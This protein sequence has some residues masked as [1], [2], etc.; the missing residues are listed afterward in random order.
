MS[1]S[2]YPTL[3]RIIER[4]EE[5]LREYP[6]CTRCL[7][8][9][10][11]KY[12]VGLSNHDRGVMI[13]TALA[14]KIYSETNTSMK[15]HHYAIATN[16]GDQVASTYTKLYREP[17]TPKPCY[18]C[19]HRL[20]R[21]LIVE[22]ARTSCELLRRHEATRF[23]VGVVI[24]RGILE[25]ELELVTKYG[26]E[27]SE[28]IKRELKREIGKAIMELCSLTPDFNIPDAVVMVSIDQSFNFKVHIEPSPIFYY[29]KYLK[30]GRNISHVPW[31]TKDGSK[32][33][34][35]S[36]QEFIENA[37]KDLFM[38]SRIVIHAAGR[39][40]VDARMLGTGRPLVIEVKE[41]KRR[42]ISLQEINKAL[43]DHSSTYPIQVTVLLKT[44]RSSKVRLKQESK[45]K[46]KIYR[47][48][49]YSPVDLRVEDLRKIED[50][51]ANREIM[52]RTPTRILK[53]KKD[54]VRTRRVFRVLTHLITSRVFEAIVYCEG[55]LY[56]KELVSGDGGRTTP[57]FSEVLNIEL[58]PLELD[59]LYVED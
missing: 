44:T 57:S 16:A 23:L 13:K 46:R 33:Y 30:L 34:P 45:K 7:G 15:E 11:A 40:D 36:V 17:I 4:S 41:P 27:T 35:I 59:V 5:I 20:T 12:G 2:F 43:A 58:K 55:G 3:S 10:F 22:I 32:K 29:G 9:L 8:R 53:R 49:V 39:E 52:Q 51:L 42:N 26:T 31:I 48:V 38:A 25:R 37:L 19:G 14:L 21:D 18:I 47:V 1:G 6:L 24:D 54:R 56:I 50:A 28:S